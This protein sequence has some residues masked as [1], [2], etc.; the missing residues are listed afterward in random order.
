MSN[1]YKDGS[2]LFVT[3]NGFPFNE[4]DHAA[5]QDAA[6]LGRAARMSLDAFAKLGPDATP[7]QRSAVAC[8][9][10]DGLIV[11]G[12]LDQI[13]AEVKAMRPG[14]DDDKEDAPEII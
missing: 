13:T 4:A 2:G 11:K 9:L 7:E 8:A 5:A 14:S 6:A 1:P 10:V 12:G 3:P